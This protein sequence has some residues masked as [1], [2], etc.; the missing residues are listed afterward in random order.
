MPDVA[1]HEH[2][3]DHLPGLEQR[4]VQ[5]CRPSVLSRMFRPRSSVPKVIF[6]RNMIRVDDQQ[7]LDD[8][9]S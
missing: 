5:A 1:V 9:G 3:A 2:V 6:S 4:T 7:V 8:G